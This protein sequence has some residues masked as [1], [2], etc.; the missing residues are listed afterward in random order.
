MDEY[1]SRLT[2]ERDKAQDEAQENWQSVKRLTAE[3]AHAQ[4]TIK[5][6]EGG[7]RIMRTTL[8]LLEEHPDGSDIIPALEQLKAERDRLREADWSKNF[9]QRN[10]R[11][12]ESASGFNHRLDSWSM[13]D[14][15]VAVL[16]ELGEA[17]NIVKKLNRVRDGIPGNTTTADELRDKLSL[18]IADAYIYL[19]LLCQAEGINLQASVEKAFNG[20]SQQIGYTEAALGEKGSRE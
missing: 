7:W 10:R 11:R 13:S 15:M 5:G 9:S 14:W 19:D 16:G 17:A 18:E 20:K 12:C 3:L 1:I 2:A 8:G 6:Y 4:R